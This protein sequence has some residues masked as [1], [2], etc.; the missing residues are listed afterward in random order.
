VP[1]YQR[2]QEETA[3]ATTGTVAKHVLELGTGTGETA[4]RVLALDPAA[5]LVGLDA[6][7]EMLDRARSALPADRVEL[8][9]AHLNDPLPGGPFDVV[10][11]A[12]T[13]HHLD[14]AGKTDLFRRAATV[15]SPG[16]RFV[17][18]DVVV[19]EGPSDV[20]TPID[21]DYD[22]PSTV[23]E[24]LHRRTKRVEHH[25]YSTR[26]THYSMV[27]SAVFDDNCCGVR[28]VHPDLH[29]TA[30]YREQSI[31]DPSNCSTFDG[32]PRGTQPTATRTEASHQ[33]DVWQSPNG[34]VFVDTA[35]RDPVP[36]SSHIREIKIGTCGDF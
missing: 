25:Q 3:A 15:L 32:Y 20:M 22:R 33:G 28:L 9:V 26:Q 29:K 36:T 5:V 30:N 23:A 4:R 10:V 19:P 2:L 6:S 16:G 7:R 13:V 17:L 14:G 1:D 34:L 8:R 12:L 18:G 11:S 21:L 31:K 27:N 24:Q 35:I